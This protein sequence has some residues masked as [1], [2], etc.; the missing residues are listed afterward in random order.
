[1]ASSSKSQTYFK[2]SSVQE[3]KPKSF[4]C[5][6]IPIWVDTKEFC[7]DSTTAGAA[8]TATTATTTT[9]TATATA[10]ATATRTATATA[11]ATAT[12]TT[13]T[14]TTTATATATTTTTTSGIENSLSGVEHHLDDLAVGGVDGAHVHHLHLRVLGQL[15]VPFIHLQVRGLK[16]RA[17]LQLHN[18]LTVILCRFFVPTH[19]DSTPFSCPPMDGDSTPFSCRPWRH[20]TLY[21]LTHGDT[22]MVKI[23]QAV[24]TLMSPFCGNRTTLQPPRSANTGRSLPYLGQAFIL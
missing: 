20:H 7:A 19:G 21:V 23:F 17:H 11:T 9:T 22:T 8:A 14:T 24:Y 3:K 18:C 4:A 13:T 1:M 5:I 12:T 15:L 16:L 6:F 10:T 2:T